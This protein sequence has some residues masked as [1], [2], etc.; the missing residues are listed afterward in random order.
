MISR[1]HFSDEG[2]HSASA[3]RF[4]RHFIMKC[5]KDI[6]APDIQLK[7]LAKVVQMFCLTYGNYLIS[8]SRNHLDGQLP[9]AF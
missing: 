9:I 8:R 1:C 2:N 5:T 3:I 4:S 7:F 6:S